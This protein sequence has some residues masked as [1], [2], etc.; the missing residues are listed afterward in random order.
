MN[1]LSLQELQHQ[2]QELLEEQ[3]RK[4]EELQT[5]ITALQTKERHTLQLRERLNHLKK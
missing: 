4:Q 2:H 1:T 5:Q 3:R